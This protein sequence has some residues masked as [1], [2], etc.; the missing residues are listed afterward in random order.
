MPSCAGHVTTETVF[1]QT[2]A[3]RL[4]DGDE[5]HALELDTTGLNVKGNL[6]LIHADQGEHAERVMGFE[7]SL[8][9]G[10]GKLGRGATVIPASPLF[11]LNHHLGLLICSY[12]ESCI[13]VF[14][15]LETSLRP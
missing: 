11:L 2:L 4:G 6:Y 12:G 8:S 1:G 13:C 7:A 5:H 9:L 15:P 14:W 10:G 3:L